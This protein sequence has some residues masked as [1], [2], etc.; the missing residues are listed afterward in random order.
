M[1]WRSDLPTP[2]DYPKGAERFEA[3]LRE[4]G[5]PLR[6]VT[7]TAETVPL[8]NALRSEVVALVELEAK[9]KK[10]EGEVRTLESRKATFLKQGAGGGSGGGGGGGGSKRARLGG[11]KEA[12]GDADGGGRQDKRRKSMQ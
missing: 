2:F 10:L 1:A 5:V 12:D 4:L 3:R 11:G 8:A 6:P 7:P 9:L